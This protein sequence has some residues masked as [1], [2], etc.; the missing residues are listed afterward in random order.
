MIFD[1]IFYI[2]LWI[3]TIMQLSLFVLLFDQV[4]S[5]LLPFKMYV[6]LL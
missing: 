4:L 3:H 2:S 5:I 6:L 1:V